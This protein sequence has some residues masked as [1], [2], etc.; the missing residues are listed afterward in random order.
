MKSVLTFNGLRLCNEQKIG[1]QCCNST[2]FRFENGFKLM[3]LMSMTV[4]GGEVLRLK[5]TVYFANGKSS[6]IDV[7]MVCNKVKN[8]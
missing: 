2:V 6:C 1:I 3:N 7:K 5:D 4:F 8:V